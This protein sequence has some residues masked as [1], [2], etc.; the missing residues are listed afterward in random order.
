MAQNLTAAQQAQLENRDPTGK[1]KSK[2][3]TDVDDSDHVLGINSEPSPEAGE[4][5]EPTMTPDALED[6]DDPQER[7]PVQA[8][9]AGDY[10]DS[11]EAITRNWPPSINVTSNS[12][13]GGLVVTAAHQPDMGT[14][15]EF[16]A[17][18]HDD[19]EPYETGRW[20]YSIDGDVQAEGPLGG[21]EDEILRAEMYQDAFV[22]QA[23]DDDALGGMFDSLNQELGHREGYQVST[24]GGSFVDDYTDQQELRIDEPDG[25]AWEVLQHRH[26]PRVADMDAEE[27]LEL[28]E[29]ERGNRDYASEHY[30]CRVNPDGTRESLEGEESYESI[31]EALNEI[32][33][34]SSNFG[35]R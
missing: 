11:F 26:D 30:V 33:D 4:R 9:R 10:V 19:I 29:A 14:Y 1:F 8:N 16:Q 5:F 18:T 22:G 32:R 35:Q 12:G 34:R 6:L 27:G 7:E 28:Y 2:T 25:G 20:T 24:G 3:H 21:G 23:T 17:E 31:D 15:I 13:P